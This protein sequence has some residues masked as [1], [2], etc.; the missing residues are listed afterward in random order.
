MASR[1]HPQDSA[2]PLPFRASFPA[3]IALNRIAKSV[4]IPTLSA[5]AISY[6]NEKNYPQKPN[7]CDVLDTE[8]AHAFSPTRVSAAVISITTESGVATSGLM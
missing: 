1:V 6:P 4:L 7:L 8:L 5:P 2:E 3:P